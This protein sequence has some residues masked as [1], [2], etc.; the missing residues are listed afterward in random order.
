MY[1]TILV[2][3]DGS[4]LAERALPYAQRLAAAADGRLVLLWVVREP[5]AS[6]AGDPL[7]EVAPRRE[8]EAYLRGL[9]ERQGATP[10][11]PV[12][13]EGAAAQT[14]LGEVPRRGIELVVMSTHGRSG[15]GRWLYGSVADAVMRHAGVPVLLVPA[16]SAIG[17]WPT[18]R[19]PRILVPLDRSPL[20]EAV[21][22]PAGELAEPFDAELIL[23][24][25]TPQLVT[26]DMYGTAYLGYDID[27]DREERRR[28]LEGVAT[29]LRAAGRAVR[30]RDGFGPVAAV[31]GDV[32][33]EEGVDLIAI[34]THGSGGATRLLMGSV[35]TGVVQGA[36][37]PV[38][39]VRPAEV[40]RH[41]APP[42]EQLGVP[43]T[44]RGG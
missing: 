1:R 3:L 19:A 16:M 10:V 8:A 30:I 26:A 43:T 13:L 39:V 20:S 35:A 44:R 42:A 9:A 2:P 36:T 22:P 29:R 15:L 33:R 12:V 25:V 38:L 28:Y 17:G 5:P 37:V 11:D 23:L 31:I 14:I 24:S 18:D 27:A 6:A 7:R 21:L 40:R 41:E 34:A 32:A 4:I